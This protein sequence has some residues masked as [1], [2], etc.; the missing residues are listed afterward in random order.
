MSPEQ[1]YDQRIITLSALETRLL[2]RK[3]TL[4]Y[5]RLAGI[6]LIIATL[7][8]SGTLGWAATV[9]LAALLLAAFIRIVYKDLANKEALS[10]TALL[11][12]I[13]KNE[14][15]ALRH[16]Y[17]QFDD[18]SRHLSKDH[19]YANDMDIFG[20]A[21]LFQLINRTVSEMGSL[22]L[23]QWLQVPASK[24][25][26]YERQAAIKELA[27][28][29]TWTQELRGLGERSAIKLQTRDNLQQWMQDPP[30]FSQFKHWHWLRYFLPVVSV[31]V[32]IATIFGFL[33]L[34]IF[35]WTMLLMALV[36]FPLE[37][38]IGLVHTRLSS[39]AAQLQSLSASIHSIENEKFSS[40][41]LQQMQAGF[42]DT[43]KVAS[44]QLKK[45]NKILDRLDLRF[46]LLLVF[47]INLLFL[48]NL[49][50]VLALDK[51]KKDNDERLTNWFNLLGSFEA[52]ASLAT[53]H[54]NNSAWTFPRLHETHFYIDANN[55]GHPLIPAG[56]RV[57]N[58]ISIQQRSSILLVTGSNMAGKST[59]LRS[60]GI[61][62]VLAMAGAPVCANSF[63]LSP[64][65]LVSSMRIADNLEESTSTFYAE[66]K[67]LKTIIDM[68]NNGEKVFIL[69]DEILRGTNSMD[70]HTGSKALIKQLLE[71]EAAAIIATHDVEL[72]ALEQVHTPHIHNVHFDVQ[73]EDDE[74]YFD[75]KLKE[76]VCKSMNASIL[77]KK[78]GI[79]L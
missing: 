39:M 36:A 35:Y 71:K 30:S 18:G 12:T 13:N 67:K 28:K 15:K 76:G 74:L 43:D 33:P 14:L 23:A 64:V 52:L 9:P 1:Y 54:F 10:Y 45:L 19:L 60:V 79:D 77:M 55:M 57:N 22:Q 6:I 11:L 59:Y 75:Y 72:A 78:I 48:W 58:D 68:V 51:W 8:F 3:K 49:Q 47:P 31:S 27:E 5:M 4:A 61:N 34:N 44:L 46:N 73:V 20:H 24:L 63:E 69:L 65:Q 62:V 17:F 7:Y 26:I 56:K 41:L 42:R 29:I 66:L 2:R 21:S 37:K 53:I 70:R 16:E 50:Q 40:P 25:S 32:T 38:K